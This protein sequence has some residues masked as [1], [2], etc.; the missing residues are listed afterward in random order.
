MLSLKVKTGGQ[1]IIVPTDD[2]LPPENYSRI[3]TSS[4][5]INRLAESISNNGILNPLTVRSYKD[6]KYIIVSGERRRLAAK[7][8]GFRFV[9]CLLVAADELQSIIYD[10]SETIHSKQLH[11]LECAQAI[12]RLH[13]IFSISELSQM[14][15]IPEGAILSRIRLLNLPEN[16]KWK[17]ISSEINEGTA[18]LL[19]NI[20]D[21]NKLNKV[22]DVI[23]SSGLSF[24]EALK[25]IEDEMPKSVLVAHYKDLKVFENTVEHAIDTMT[26]S[27]IRAQTVKNE[28]NTHIVYTV[29]I[30]KMV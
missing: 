15:S 11:Y 26:A 27:G 21:E 10:L 6:G 22:T 18:N 20:K 16:I 28:N 24:N 9:P 2:I 13:G 12:D 8:A 17:I 4:E 30:N 7:K 3:V 29:T 19:C 25:I 5:E 1:I 14:L 23:I